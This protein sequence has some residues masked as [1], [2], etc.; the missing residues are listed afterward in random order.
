MRHLYRFSASSSQ[1]CKT[2]LLW[3]GNTVLSIAFH[4]AL[5]DII[6]I[7]KIESFTT[8]VNTQIRKQRENEVL[9]N[10]LLE[11]EEQD[12]WLAGDEEVISVS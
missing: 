1:E 7:K 2:K 12:V 4:H 11:M 9:Q 6:Q 3:P 8:N 5:F 10:F